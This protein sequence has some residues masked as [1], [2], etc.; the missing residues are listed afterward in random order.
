M[1]STKGLN[2][3]PK[4]TTSV[5]WHVWSVPSMV[6]LPL[7]SILSV[8]LGLGGLITN[9]TTPLAVVGPEA[10]ADS[11]SAESP[12]NTGFEND[13]CAAMPSPAGRPSFNTCKLT[14]S[15]RLLKIC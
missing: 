13:I 1:A 3:E 11:G 14:A 15:G 2:R 5:L 4:P 6:T 12:G 10:S 7:R 9:F 8:L